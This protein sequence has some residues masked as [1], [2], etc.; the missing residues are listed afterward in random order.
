MKQKINYTNSEL[1]SVVEVEDDTTTSKMEIVT[2]INTK[3]ETTLSYLKTSYTYNV[4]DAKSM[5]MHHKSECQ[6]KL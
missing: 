1:V 3:E 6:T 2:Q 5:G 4:L